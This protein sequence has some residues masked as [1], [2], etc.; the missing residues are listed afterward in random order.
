MLKFNVEFEFDIRLT[1]ESKF[2]YKND[3]I[4]MK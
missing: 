1:F 2:I 3:K 4:G